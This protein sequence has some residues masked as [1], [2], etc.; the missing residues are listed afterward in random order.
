[1]Q[2]IPPGDLQSKLQNG[3]ALLYTPS[4]IFGWI[5]AMKTWHKVSHVEVYSGDGFSVASRDG[6][7]VG[8]YNYRADGLCAVLRPNGFYHHEAAM[9]WFDTV[10]GQ[11][12]D[13]KGILVFSMAVRQGAQ[14][15]MFCSEFATRLYRAGGLEPFQTDEDADHIAPFQFLT[16]PRFD[17]IWAA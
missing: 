14:D 4:G 17:R 8:I 11:K 12:Y 6:E 16:S 3:D 5:I 2:S 7:G 9:R 13:W 15:R 10:D 1:M